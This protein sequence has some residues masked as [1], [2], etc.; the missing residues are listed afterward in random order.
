MYSTRK[1]ERKKERKKEREAENV[2]ERDVPIL[3]G[4]AW[5]VGWSARFT[6]VTCSLLERRT[7]TIL[8]A[9]QYQKLLVKTTIA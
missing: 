1:R 3:S 7:L 8:G 5:K 6:A 4:K 9:S 2:G